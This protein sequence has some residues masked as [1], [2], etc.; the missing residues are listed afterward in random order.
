MSR[1][2]HWT[3]SLYLTSYVSYPEPISVGL[4]VSMFIASPGHAEKLQCFLLDLL[5]ALMLL[6]YL[7]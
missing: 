7:F 3:L 1:F 5:L 4:G 2:P 6:H